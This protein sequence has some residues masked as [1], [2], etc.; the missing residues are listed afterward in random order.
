MTT[1]SGVTQLQA[2]ILC[3]FVLL[4]T[5][6]IEG[7]FKQNFDDSVLFKGLAALQVRT[8]V[9]GK[10]SRRFVQSCTITLRLFSFYFEIVLK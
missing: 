3:S 8:K 7:S 5:T 6:D 1:F 4:L 10:T 9:T 2:H